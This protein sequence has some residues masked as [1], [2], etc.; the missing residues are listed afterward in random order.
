[1]TTVSGEEVTVD[2]AR[3]AH[4][5]LEYCYEQEW[6][7]GLP[8]VPPLEELVRPLIDHAG[9]DPQEVIARADHLDRNCTIELAAVNSVMAGCLPEHFPVVV[10]AIEAL[11]AS[12]G[13]NWAWCQ[14]TSGQAQM[15]IVNG[16]V[17]ESA[18]FNSKVNVFGD[19]FRANATVGR[20]VRLIIMNAL[21]IRPHEFDQ[22]TQGTPLKYT[23]CIA[24]NE[25][26]NPWDSWHVERGYPAEASVV[27][28]LYVRSALHVQTARNEPESILLAIA[29]S[30]STSSSRGR[31]F[32]VAMSPQHA[33]LIATKGWSKADV[34]QFLAE[35]WGRPRGELRRLG[36]ERAAGEGPDA[37]FVN[38]GGPDSILLVVT[39]GFTNSISTVIPASDLSFDTKEIRQR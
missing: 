22:S 13:A 8:V 11:D 6:T 27:T 28:A 34:K 14:S 32:V 5:V 9:R 15:V 4:R 12:S 19:G 20:A 25:E 26:E 31:G 21:G 16:P 37:E 29:D 38:F 2:E 17:R 33:H 10:A 23:T 30:M 39:G 7:D 3:T 1:M 18:G 24:E 35:H 36:V